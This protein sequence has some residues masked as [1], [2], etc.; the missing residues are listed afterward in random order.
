M[1]KTVFIEVKIPALQQ[2]FDFRIS[3]NMTVHDVIH[4]IV[5]C[6]MQIGGNETWAAGELSLCLCNIDGVLAREKTV[7]EYKI[8]SGDSLVLV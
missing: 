2:Y 1:L 8:V 7:A 4:A 3:K 6:V 5:G